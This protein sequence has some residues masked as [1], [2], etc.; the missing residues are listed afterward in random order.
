MAAN[1]LIPKN[2]EDEDEEFLEPAEVLRRLRVEFAVVEVDKDAAREM[3]QQRIDYI[4]QRLSEGH[5]PWREYDETLE[6][7]RSGIDDAHLVYFSDEPDAKA[8]FLNTLV[9]PNEPLFFGYES[10]AQE[11]AAP[12]LLRRC[13]K[14][15]G[16]DLET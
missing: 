2:F 14:A 6:R 3:V 9:M 1:R 7:L 11:K 12:K 13:A 16:Y 5:D 4:E 15:L 10:A 8:A